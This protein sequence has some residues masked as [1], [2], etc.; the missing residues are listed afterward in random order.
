MVE[1]LALGQRVRHARQQAGLTL[2]DLSQQVGVTA[3]QLS[4]VETGKREAKISLLS[5]LA[6]ALSVEV[7]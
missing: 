1:I 3:S 4:L 6:S 7:S 5:S 2:E